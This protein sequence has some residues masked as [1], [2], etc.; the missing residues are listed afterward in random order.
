MNEL[1]SK[2]P[3]MSIH[4]LPQVSKKSETMTIKIF[5]PFF[6]LKPYKES[7]VHLLKGSV[8]GIRINGRIYINIFNGMGPNLTNVIW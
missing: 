4:K 7:T 2:F 5:K 8:N 6:S 3:N 1:V